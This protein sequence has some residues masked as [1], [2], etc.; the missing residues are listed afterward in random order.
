MKRFVTCRW[1]WNRPENERV[2]GKPAGPVS[3]KLSAALLWEPRDIWVGLYWTHRDGGG[4]RFLYVCLLP[5]LPLR[6]HLKTSYSGRF[7][8]KWFQFSFPGG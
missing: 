1:T 6:V 3:H 5:C 4:S 2:D 7:P 8:A